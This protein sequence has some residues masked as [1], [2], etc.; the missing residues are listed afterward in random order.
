MITPHIFKTYGFHYMYKTI[1]TGEFNP[2]TITIMLGF[3]VPYFMFLFKLL[4]SSIGLKV[5]HF[6]FLY[7]LSLRFWTHFCLLLQVSL[8]IQW[9]LAPGP[10]QIPWSVEAQVFHI[11]WLSIVSPLC[12]HRSPV[13]R[14]N[15]SQ[16]E[17]KGWLYWFPK[18]PSHLPF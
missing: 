1:G 12:I 4:F 5:I 11:K 2:F 16:M 15:Q 3:L 14:F 8:V 13:H 7:F 10:L 6:L 9:G 17:I 18:P